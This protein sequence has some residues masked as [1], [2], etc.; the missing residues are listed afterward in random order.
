MSSEAVSEEDYISG[1]ESDYSYESGSKDDLG[2]AGSDKQLSFLE[3]DKHHAIRLEDQMNNE[4]LEV[5][6]RIFEEADEDGGG[7]L[8]YEEFRRAMIKT[9]SCKEVPDD[10]Q[11]A[12]TF[13]KVDAN[14]DGTVDWEEFCSYMLLENQLKDVMTSDEREM[15]FPH[16]AREIPSAHR[17]NIARITYFA[18]M[19]HGPDESGDNNVGRYV[20]V[21][22]EGVL[23]FW[24]MDLNPIRTIT[25]SNASE[26]KASKSVWI[27]D[28]VVLPN[29]KKIA[30][31]SADREIAFYDCS[32]NSV[33]KQFVLSGLENCALCMDYW[34]DPRH[35]NQS[36]LLFGDSGG[37][38]SCI[39]F[40]A[41]NLGLFD[42][43]IGQTI[44]SG[45][46][47]ISGR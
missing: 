30:V 16:P 14:C 7:G 26:G 42:L 46:T 28:C 32:A 27:T 33:E 12:I 22:R 39:K 24:S 43:N 2:S 21:S 19:S 20:T 23:H 35:P 9:M 6:Q 17:D 4:H 18:K 1:S 15:E 41:V 3:E 34:Y 40:S 13:M 25:V 5:L 31:S 10:N 8:D 29:A 37:K 44:P 47:N 45:N 36:I 38:V 11:L